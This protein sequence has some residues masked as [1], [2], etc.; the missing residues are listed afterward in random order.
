MGLP[1]WVIWTVPVDEELQSDLRRILVLRNEVDLPR[2]D[3]TLF[4]QC[5]WVPVGDVFVVMFLFYDQC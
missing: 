2:L 1:R 5:G 3:G 4:A